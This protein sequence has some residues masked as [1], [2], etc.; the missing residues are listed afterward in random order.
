MAS[1]FP[2]SL[3]DL[4][5]AV[6]TGALAGM[7]R[8]PRADMDGLTLTLVLTLI[9][10]FFSCHHSIECPLTN[11]PIYTALVDVLLFQVWI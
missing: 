4:N 2:S 3:T 5:P 8:R 6:G 9:F 10:F 1:T 7:K 11:K